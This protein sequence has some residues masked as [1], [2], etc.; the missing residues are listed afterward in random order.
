MCDLW[1]VEIPLFRLLWLH[2]L[3]RV[4]PL[5]SRSS[6]HIFWGVY[7]YMRALLRHS[8]DRRALQAFR[9]RTEL[10]RAGYTRR[11]LV[12]MGLLT[13]GGAGGGLIWADKSLAA[14]QG[15]GSLGSL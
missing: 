1:A 11:E 3:G 5:H 6:G 14:G 7:T 2:V 8:G 4:P 9:E 10:V 12:K 13:T 15:N